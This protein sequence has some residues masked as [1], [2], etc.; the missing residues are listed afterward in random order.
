MIDWSDMQTRRKPTRKER[1]MY[2]AW[3]KYLKDSRLSPDEVHK[4]AARFTEQRLVVPND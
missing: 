1:G 2:Q 3:V 4:R